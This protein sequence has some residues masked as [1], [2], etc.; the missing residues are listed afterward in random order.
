MELQTIMSSLI[1]VVQTIQQAIGD[2]Q[3]SVSGGT[4]PATDILGFDSIICVEAITMLSIDLD[5]EIAD[6]INIFVSKD[7]QFLTIDQAAALVYEGFTK[8]ET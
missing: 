8:G 3:S 7:G 5:V 2:G 4:C 6:N 1:G